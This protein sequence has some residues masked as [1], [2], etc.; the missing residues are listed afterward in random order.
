VIPR[1]VTRDDVGECLG[2]LAIEIDSPEGYQSMTLFLSN[3]DV[4]KVLTMEDAIAALEESYRLLNTGEAV[5]VPRVDVEI[6]TSD[7]NK[8]YQ[9]GDMKGGSTKG[10]FAIRIKSDVIYEQEYNGVITQERYCMKPGLFCGLIF[11]TST[12]NGEPLAF[13]NDGVLQHMRVGADGGIGVKHLSR[14]NARVVGMLGSGG[15]ART[16]MDA[17]ICVREIERLQVFS[18]TPANR[19]AFA[20]EVRKKHGIEVIVCDQPRDVYKGADILAGVTDSALP[21]IEGAFVEPGTHITNVGAG[22]HPDDATLAKVDVYLRFGDASVPWGYSREDV[23][24][25]NFVY[26][27][28]P[29]FNANLKLNRTGKRAHVP[30]LPDRMITLNDIQSGTNRGRTAASQ[31][32]YSERGNTQGAQFFAAAGMVYEKSKALGLGPEIPT[33]WLLQDIRD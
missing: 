26:A 6:P 5:C 24:G 13:I 29:D 23:D 25:G 20:E 28:R 19:E 22:G 14:E 30:K 17:F 27:A 12:D 1:N 32:T 2:L 16:H 7:P 21:V 10:Y 9:W 15:M 18:P 4:A 11:L 3:D 33:E 31:I 8:M